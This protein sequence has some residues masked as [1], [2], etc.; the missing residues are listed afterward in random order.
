M[1]ELLLSLL[2]GFIIGAIFTAIKLPIPAPPV[3]SGI[4][5]IFGVWAGH[6]AILQ[7]MARFFS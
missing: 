3:L 2:A 4:V 1:T 5:A 7:V 6:H